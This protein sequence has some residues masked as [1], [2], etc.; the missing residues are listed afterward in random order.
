[1]EKKEYVLGERLNDLT[2]TS[3]I[4]DYVERAFYEKQCYENVVPS[5]VRGVVDITPPLDDNERFKAILEKMETAVSEFNLAMGEIK[6]MY[7]E[8]YPQYED[9]KDEISIVINFVDSRVL[10]TYGAGGCADGSC[11]I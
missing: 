7:M 3:G 11:G 4:I 5:I 1:M 8:A 10:A 2:L 9:I 6:K